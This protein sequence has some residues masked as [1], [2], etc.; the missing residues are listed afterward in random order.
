MLLILVGAAF[1][2]TTFA[3][4]LMAFRTLRVD[5]A[6]NYADEDPR[7][8]AGAMPGREGRQ[9]PLW[10]V[11]SRHGNALILGELAL[12]IAFAVAAMATDSFWQRRG[13]KE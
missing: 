7:S 8:S 10:Q 9:H 5:A 13:K 3:Y 4:A 11:L 12:V 1:V 6:A 2:V